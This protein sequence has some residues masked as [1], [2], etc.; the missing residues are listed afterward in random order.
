MSTSRQLGHARATFRRGRLASSPRVWASSQGWVEATLAMAQRVKS[1]FGRAL[2][3]VGGRGVRR[4]SPTT[5][6]GREFAAR[7]DSV[8]SVVSMVPQC[9]RSRTSSLRRSV[10]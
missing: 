3:T 8:D 9:F 10:A 1:D 2:G 7:S 5:A 6:E 4:N